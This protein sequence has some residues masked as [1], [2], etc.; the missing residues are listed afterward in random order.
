MYSFS[1]LC[2]LQASG[3]TYISLPTFFFYILRFAVLISDLFHFLLGRCTELIASS[4]HLFCVIRV[5]FRSRSSVRKQ[6]SPNRMISPAV[7]LV[8]PCLSETNHRLWHAGDFKSPTSDATNSNKLTIN[9]RPSLGDDIS[10]SF[11]D[12]AQ[13]TLFPR[14]PTPSA[15]ECMVAFSPM[16]KYTEKHTTS[17]PL[18]RRKRGFYFLAIYIFLARRS[19]FFLSLLL[20]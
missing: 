15:S 19:S 14:L 5:F 20:I 8:Y 3:V 11:S 16:V 1:F 12:A 4:S 2:F 7:Y 6:P 10:V 13:T 18:S 17:P 9:A